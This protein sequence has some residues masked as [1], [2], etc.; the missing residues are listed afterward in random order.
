MNIEK[1][2]EKFLLNNNN[3]ISVSIIDSGFYNIPE[4]ATIYGFNKNPSHYHGNRVLSIFRALDKKYP[5]SNLKLNLSC[6][7][8]KDDYS[9]LFN[10]IYKLPESDIL[11]ISISWKEDKP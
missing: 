2:S 5:I 6:Y 8:S 11:S 10:A 3:R 7:D 9:G 1:I 4:Y